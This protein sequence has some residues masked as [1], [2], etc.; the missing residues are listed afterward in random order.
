MLHAQ[1]IHHSTV[2]KS[3]TFMPG[4]LVT[5][6]YVENRFFAFSR[7]MICFPSFYSKTGHMITSYETKPFGIAIIRWITFFE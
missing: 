5:F 3:F 7:R 6:N 4:M 1:R 2:W